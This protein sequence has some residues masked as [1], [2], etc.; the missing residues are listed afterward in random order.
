[1]KKIIIVVSVIVA[2]TLVIFVSLKMNRQSIE[3]KKKFLQM[4]KLF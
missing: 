1:M 2:L 3:A 4:L